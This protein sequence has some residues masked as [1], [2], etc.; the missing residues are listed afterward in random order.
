MVKS[1][2][3]VPRGLVS[4]VVSRLGLKV[5]PPAS[6]GGYTQSTTNERHPTPRTS[7][8]VPVLRGESTPVKRSLPSLDSRRVGVTSARPHGRGSSP[9]VDPSNELRNLE[10][11]EYLERFHSYY[12]R[13][14]R[15]PP[16]LPD[17]SCCRVFPELSTIKILQS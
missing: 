8:R 11:N 6:K 4:V 1:D 16:R 12:C 14:W 15:V 13:G 5:V 7:P 3:G 17:K 2:R 10:R 9:D